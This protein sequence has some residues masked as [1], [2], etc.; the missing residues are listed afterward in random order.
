MLASNQFRQDFSITLVSS[1]GTDLVAAGGQTN[2]L[3]NFT[4]QINFAEQNLYKGE[5]QMCLSSFYIHD[6]FENDIHNN[7]IKAYRVETDIINVWPNIHNAGLAIVPRK[8]RLANSKLRGVYYEPVSPEYYPLLTT[9]C[10]S[11]RIQIY[12]IDHRGAVIKDAKL[13]AGQPTI[14]KLSFKNTMYQD[15]TIRVLKLQS[16]E[17][18]SQYFKSNTCVDFTIEAQSF[19]ALT[20]KQNVEY[21]CALNSISYLASFN[22]GGR[23]SGPNVISLYNPTTKTYNKHALE[24]L[25]PEQIASPN[26]YFLYAQSQ[27]STLTSDVLFGTKNNIIYLTS[28][29][30][31]PLTIRF[32]MYFIYNLGLRNF[33]QPGLTIQ[34]D[35]QID[36]TLQPGALFSLDTTFKANAYTPEIGFIYCD[37]VE[38]SQVGNTM[39][40]IIGSFPIQDLNENKY[41]TF[42]THNHEWFPLAKF[43]LSRMKFSLRDVTGKLLPFKN[44]QSNLILSVLIK[45]RDIHI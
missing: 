19:L 7:Q 35:E 6:A 34:A 20:P 10:N 22:E 11:I 32:P 41:V 5:W 23:Q 38:A 15:T 1:A 17:P 24:K 14:I 12:P 21:S 28:G 27:L 42:S 13:L 26:K 4:N 44:K 45:R 43:D 33:S 8:H 25:T 31:K 37:F 29:N 30:A 18:S 40:P 39:C 16:A 36:I 2:T 9:Q 3:V